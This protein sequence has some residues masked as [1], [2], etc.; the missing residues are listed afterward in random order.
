MK[1]IAGVD[2]VGRG[3]LAGPVYSAAVIL[4]KNHTLNGLEDS[5]KIS[6]K[7][8]ESLYIDIKSQAISIGIGYSDVKTIDKINIRE[9][10]FLA[11]EM[12][13]NN[14]SK[15][16]DY[17]LIDGF[18]LKNQ[19]IPNEGIIKG[20]TIHDNI[21]AASIIAKVIRDDLMSKYNLI[22]PEY[23]FLKNNGYGTK[24][25]IQ[26]LKK[27]KATPVHRKTFRKVS[28]NIPTFK[29]LFEKNKLK[30]MGNKIAGLFILEEIKRMKKKII[31]TDMDE[32]FFIII[33]NKT[34]VFVFVYTKYKEIGS[35]FNPKSALCLNEIKD[36]SKILIDQ[37]IK[38]Q[39]NFRFDII[40]VTLEK[41]NPRIKHIKNVNT[42]L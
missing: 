16:P 34:Y 4:P 21:K 15:K 37:T 13:L 40:N 8:R 29:W 28:E 17:A 42:F 32:G 3:P 19:D 24:E 12:A 36:S 5:K 10:S 14:L 20:D 9:A 18:P 27:Y 30:W 31:K 33:E 6:K 22:F 41:G 38:E 39:S 35:L 7:K 25:H 2:E 1:L 23:N 11:M 26:A